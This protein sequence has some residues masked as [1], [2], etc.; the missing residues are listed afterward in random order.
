LAD[1]LPVHELRMLQ[2]PQLGFQLSH[3]DL[4]IN[5]FPMPNPLLGWER[6]TYGMSISSQLM[7]YVAMAPANP[8]GN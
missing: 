2:H 7:L 8:N 6:I 1:V 4:L 3:L 5:L